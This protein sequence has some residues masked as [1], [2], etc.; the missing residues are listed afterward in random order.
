MSTGALGGWCALEGMVQP[1]LFPGH[2]QEN[3]RLPRAW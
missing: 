2:R 1:L 3:L